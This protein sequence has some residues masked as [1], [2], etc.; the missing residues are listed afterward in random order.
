MNRLTTTTRGTRSTRTTR[1]TR[2]AVS[3]VAVAAC[4]LATSTQADGA[5]GH[6]ASVPATGTSSGRLPVLRTESV[7]PH[8]AAALAASKGI[9]LSA[10]TARLAREQGLGNTAKQIE[11]GLGAR[12]GGSYLDA[13][14]QLVVTTVDAAGDAAV[15]RAGATAH[16][17]HNSSAV[18]QQI[19][20]RLDAMATTPQGAGSVQGWYVD[21]VHNTVVVTATAGAV[22]PGAAAVLKVARSLGTSVRVEEAPASRAPRPTDYLA[23]GYQFVPVTGGTCSVGFNTVDASNRNVVLTA[24]HCTRTTGNNSRNG[25]IIGATRTSNFPG[26]DFGTFWNSYPGYWRPSPSVYT[27]QYGTY[28]AVKGIVAAP[29]I[30][31]QICK[32]GRTTGWTCGTIVAGNQTVNYPEGTVRNLVRHNACV[33]GGDSGG[34]N[35]NAAGYALGVTSGAAMVN[36]RCQGNGTSV[37]YY[38]PISPAL[39]ANGLRLLIG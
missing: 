23:G 7:E 2:L 10:A 11:G 18:L 6:E 19:V 8:A 1:V 20:A 3:A 14:G 25:L 32:S 38:Q 9:S 21:V 31:S 16:R 15:A 22:D 26:T 33:E 13:Q 39:N 30:G 29:L 12:T 24:G 34:S 17:V 4:L 28:V 5:A 37:S 36:G 27:W 35:V